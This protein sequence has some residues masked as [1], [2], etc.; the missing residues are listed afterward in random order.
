MAWCSRQLSAVP[1]G[2]YP[3]H[4]SSGTMARGSGGGEWREYRTRDSSQS[5]GVGTALPR[6]RGGGGGA[7]GRRGEGSG[8]VGGGGGAYR[9]ARRVGPGVALE[10]VDPGGGDH[11]GPDEVGVDVRLPA[12]CSRNCGRAGKRRER[13]GWQAEWRGKGRRASKTRLGGALRCEEG[14]RRRSCFSFL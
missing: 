12:H 11:A 4:E 3:K 1:K 14:Y 9:E 5:G 2:H 8:W 6:E 13:E 7:G 10:V